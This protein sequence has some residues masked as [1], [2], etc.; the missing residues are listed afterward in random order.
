MP[1]IGFHHSEAS[2]RKMSKSR[3]GWKD[4]PETCKK[5]RLALLRHWRNPTYRAKMSGRCREQSNKWSGGRSIDKRKGY[6]LIH[7]PTH[8]SRVAGHYVYEHRLVIESFIGRF[9]ERKEVVHHL[10]KKDDNRPHRLMAFATHSA[11]IRFENNPKNVLPEEI[12]SM[13]ESCLALINRF[14]AIPI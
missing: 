7:N 11:H 1:K 14:F 6:V 3:T 13:D 10:G 9:L 12:F 8:P 5:K 4:S 2:K